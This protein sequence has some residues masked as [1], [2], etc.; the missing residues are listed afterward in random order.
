MEQIRV[1]DRGRGPELADVRITVYDVLPYLQE[2]WQPASIG[3]VFG[4]SSE[5][6][7][8]LVRYFEEHREEVLAENQ[9]ILDRIARRH[10]PEV[11]AR[12][13]EVHAKFLARC[14][15]LRRRQG[16]ANGHAGNPG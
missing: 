7:E 14:E 9:K 2:G 1:I 6:V 12:L 5:H 13:E 15:E 8:A 11:E 3:M 4:I 16:G 10:P